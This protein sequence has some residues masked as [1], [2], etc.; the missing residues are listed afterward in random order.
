M[1]EYQTAMDEIN[2]LSESWQKEIEQ[3]YALIDKKESEF[4]EV[5][6]ILPAEAKKSRMEE[7][8]NMKKDA[9]MTQ[10]DYFGVN[11][12]LFQ[13]RAELIKPIQDKVFNAIQEVASEKKYA[14][15][16]D[17]ANQS[18]LIFA[19]PKYDISDLVLRKLGVNK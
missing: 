19:D 9:R 14:F 4:Q 5:A 18:N 6:A 12:Q 3:K 10:K 2:R 16:F 8:E 7:I 15:V 17:K 13:K 1:P 11:G